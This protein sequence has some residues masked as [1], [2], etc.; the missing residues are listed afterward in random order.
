VSEPLESL[1]LAAQQLGQ[2]DPLVILHGLLGSGSNWRSIARSLGEQRTV[3]L[4]DARNHGASPHH[5]HMGYPAMAADTLA[6]M[7]ARGLQCVDLVGHSMGGKTAMWLALHAPQRVR[8]LIVVDIAP[9]PSPGHHG[10]LLTLLRRLPV[11]HMQRRAEVDAALAEEVPDNALRAFIALNLVSKDGGLAW[12]INLDAIA[13]SL[14][15]LMDFPVCDGRYD[16]PV[17]FLAGSGSD[18]VGAAHERAI[19]RL[20]PSAQLRHITGAG[21]WLHAEQPAAF[22]REANAFLGDAAR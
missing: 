21:H 11:E 22:L 4:P 20:F 2:G 18:Y 7:D 5:P 19:T 8:S 6:F 10:P 14:P 3:Y 1:P 9:A 17:L 15:V 16:G 13:E 12:R